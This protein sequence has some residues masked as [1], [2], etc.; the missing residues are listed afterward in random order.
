M[1]EADDNSVMVLDYDRIREAK[2][3]A[4]VMFEIYTSFVKMEIRGFSGKRIADSFRFLLKIFCGKADAKLNDGDIWGILEM[5]IE[6]CT[7]YLKVSRYKDGSR[8]K[9]ILYSIYQNIKNPDLS[10]QYLAKEV[11]FMNEDY[12]GRFVSTVTP[13]RNTLR[14]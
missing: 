2:D 12:F 11:L 9:H 14:F 13:M 7:A 6:E 10:L 4:E 5:V 3:Y 8:M 1:G